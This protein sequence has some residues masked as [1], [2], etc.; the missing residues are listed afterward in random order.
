[1]RMPGHMVKMA[2]VPF[3]KEQPNL[4]GCRVGLIDEQG[5]SIGVL[6]C[7]QTRDTRDVTIKASP[8]L[9]Y[10]LGERAVISIERRLPNVEAIEAT[11][12]AE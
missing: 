10:K 6:L 12:D 11:Q 1:M 7:I 9:P 5:R 8:T 4:V 2:L 3:D